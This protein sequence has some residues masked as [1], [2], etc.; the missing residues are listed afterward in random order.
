MTFMDAYAESGGATK[1]GVPD[2]IQLIRPSKKVSR[3]VSMRAVMQPDPNLNVGLMD[4]D[5]IYVPKR[6]VAR[7]GYLLQQFAPLSGMAIIGLEAVK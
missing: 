3:Q 4:G 5:I 2:R 7:F 6:G 1:D